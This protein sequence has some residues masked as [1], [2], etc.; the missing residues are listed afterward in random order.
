MDYTRT[1]LEAE[2]LALLN[3]EA[4]GDVIAWLT[5]PIMGVI[6]DEEDPHEH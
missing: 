3:S 5:S 2:R 1:T 4:R 6:H